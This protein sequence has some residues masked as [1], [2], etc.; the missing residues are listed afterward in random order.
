M[1]TESNKGTVAEKVPLLAAPE[2]MGV[3]MLASKEPTE[4]KND[5]VAKMF[6]RCH[7]FGNR[8]NRNTQ[9]NEIATMMSFS[10]AKK[11][12]VYCAKFNEDHLEIDRQRI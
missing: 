11:R 5:I 9:C 4:P 7:K 3:H 8:G 10:G 12:L 1:P 6:G 2:K